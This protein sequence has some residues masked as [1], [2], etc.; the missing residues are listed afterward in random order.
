VPR[1]NTTILQ[2]LAI[3]ALC[4]AATPLAGC[5]GDRTQKPPRQ[6][7]P[8][9]DDQPKYKAQAESSFFADQRTAREPVAG[10]V[11]FGKRYELVYGSTEQER[12]MF[13]EQIAMERRQFLRVDDTLVRG[14]DAQGNYLKRIP[15]QTVLGIPE[16]EA[17]PEADMRRF[18]ELGKKNYDINCAIC[19]GGTGEG[20]G[21]VGQQ[22]SY[23][24][25]SFHGPQY[26]P[27]G[28]K[29][30]DGYIFHTIRN[31]VANTPGVQPALKMPAYSERIDVE[32]AWAVVA[33]FRAL[34]RARSAQLDEIPDSAR[35][36]LQQTRPG[37]AG[38]GGSP[39]ENQMT[40]PQ[41]G[42]A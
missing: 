23:P 41:E 9:L 21:L 3:L 34:Q 32:E 35:Q 39:G 4:L 30:Q 26:Q 36:R 25:P 31:G 33:Y 38:Q 1:A 13:R 20:N 5:R 12:E 15:I 10:T 42:G 6:F 8:G 14:V 11:A 22:W 7:F 18:V 16:G 19:H 2:A 37:S 24:L 17:I 29:G 28:E 27:G 40:S